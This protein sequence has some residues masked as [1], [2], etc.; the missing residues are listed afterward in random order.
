MVLVQVPSPVHNSSQQVPYN[1]LYFRTG[2][3]MGTF[4]KWMMNYENLTRNHLACLAPKWF[5]TGGC[6]LLLVPP[7]LSKKQCFL[8]V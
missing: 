5:S 2:M 7:F 3:Q 8:A 4:Q 1:H 6:F